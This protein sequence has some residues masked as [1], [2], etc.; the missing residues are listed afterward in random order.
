MEWSL[1][2][3]YLRFE[4]KGSLA[5]C[6]IDRPQARN[7]LTLGMYYG[8]K[9]AVQIVNS[10]PDLAALIIT[11]VGEVF[12][13]G[14]DLGGGDDPGGPLPPLVD[15]ELLPFVAIRNSRA[16][17]I[18]AVN[19]LCLAGGMLI[20]MVA[21]VAVASERA[22]FGVP[23]LLR[24]IPDATCASVIPAHVGVAVARDLMLTGRRIGAGE[25]VRAGVISRVAAHDALHN[26]AVAAAEEILQTAPVARM[27][28]KRMLNER[29]GPID[30]QTQYWAQY[31]SPEPQEGMRAFMDKRKPRW[32]PP[33]M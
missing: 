31:E 4:T 11:G 29:Y 17:V 23:E 22:T 32:V 14:G 18:A 10:E 5:W 1:G 3:A 13:S 28:A 16:P 2:S 27:H 6:V 7:A 24:G 15:E 21:D 8:V 20:A 26:E 25:A 12:S 19:G 30:Y 9:R 33:D